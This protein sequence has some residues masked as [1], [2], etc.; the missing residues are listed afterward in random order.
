M[1]PA[2]DTD[3][4]GIAVLSM[5]GVIHVGFTKIV[6]ALTYT[7]DYVPTVWDTGHAWSLAIEEQ[8]YLLW[9]AVLAFLGKRRAFQVALL[10]VC[11]EPFVRVL[12]FAL[13]FR[14]EAGPLGFEFT[15]HADAL[16]LGCCLAAT[17][18]WLHA[19]TAYMRL[20]QSPAFF[21]I[22]TLVLLIRLTLGHA[23]GIVYV[24][25]LF[26]GYSVLNLGI[27][28]T[29]DWCMTYPAGVVGRTLNSRLFVSLGVLSYSIYIWQ[30]IFLDPYSLTWFTRPGVN[31][32]CTL[33]AAALSY[34]LIERTFLRWRE[35]WEP[36]LFPVTL[37]GRFEQHPHGQSE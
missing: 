18:A 7:A 12:I 21:L 14:H 15:S 16:A 20:L 35:A 1:V 17:R 3:L 6:P 26:A 13:F 24:M 10:V 23:H 29:L 27:A 28:L 11:I 36:R 22:P 33:V 2:V 31:L 8:F 37:P 5:L 34:W 25:Y 32:V 30:E 4:A 19:R 9:P